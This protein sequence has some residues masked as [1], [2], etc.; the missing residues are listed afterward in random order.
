MKTWHTLHAFLIKLS[1]SLIQKACFSPPCNTQKCWI[2]SSAQREQGRRWRTHV[3]LGPSANNV[4]RQRMNYSGW[5]WMWPRATASIRLLGERCSI[6]AFKYTALSHLFMKDCI[7]NF[8]CLGNEWV[9]LGRIFFVQNIS[10][11]LFWFQCKKWLRQSHSWKAFMRCTL[12]KRVLW[13]SV[14]SYWSITAEGH[15]AKMNLLLMF[16]SAWHKTNIRGRSFQQRCNIQRDAP[17]SEWHYSFRGIAW[18]VT[19]L[20]TKVSSRASWRLFKVVASHSF[21]ANRRQRHWE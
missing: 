17:L 19:R 8:F 2:I 13:M 12:L 20:T 1:M 9:V 3:A 5:G 10:L 18:L 11:Y 7:N 16:L 14:L 15:C 21:H 4:E 6:N